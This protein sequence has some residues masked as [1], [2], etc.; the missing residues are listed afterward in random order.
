MLTKRNLYVYIF[1]YYG[2]LLENTK[3]YK[4]FQEDLTQVSP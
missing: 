2:W 3:N 4:F 1:T